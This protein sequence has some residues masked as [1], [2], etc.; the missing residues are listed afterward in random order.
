LWIH[1]PPDPGMSIKQIYHLQASHI[2]SPKGEMMSFSKTRASESFPGL[3]FISELRKVLLGL[4]AC[5]AL[6]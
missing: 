6:L 2:S 4:M 5:L 1:I 3:G